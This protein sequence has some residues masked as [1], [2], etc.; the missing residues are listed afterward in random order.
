V[1]GLNTKFKLEIGLK[2]TI[3]KLYPDIIWFKQGIFLI[4]SFN[5]SRATNNFTI[6]IQGKDKMS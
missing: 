2:N 3:N 1:W 6:A 4:S 5:T